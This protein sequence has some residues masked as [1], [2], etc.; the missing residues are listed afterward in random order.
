MLYQKMLMHPNPYTVGVE[1]HGTEFQL[2]RHP[3]LEF[4][5]CVSGSGYTVTVKGK[6]YEI[7]PQT[8]TVVTPMADHKYTRSEDSDAVNVTVTLGSVF[9]GEYFKP[10]SGAT[11]K[12][13]AIDVSSDEFSDLRTAFEEIAALNREN[14]YFSK[15]T[16]HGDLYRICARIL[17]SVIIPISEESDP[18][19]L[20]GVSRIEKALEYIE[21]DY[22]EKITVAS[23]AA[24]CGYKES[25]FC[26]TFKQITG[27]TFHSALNK[28]RV[29]TACYLL[30]STAQPLDEIAE[31]VGFDDAK[32]LC[33]VFRRELNCT[34]TEYR[35]GK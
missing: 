15:L 1:T 8:L 29:E 10:F 27:M 26:K 13:A 7:K 11:L 24:L 18:K 14:T 6:S 3:E 33:R 17:Q 31:S 19:A 20:L 23:A 4:N 30:K 21:T 5:Y 9:L 34:P 35:E 16:V 12:D 22:R 2:H 32:S 25:N 28:R